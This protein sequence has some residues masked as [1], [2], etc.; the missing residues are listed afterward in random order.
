MVPWQ[1]NL[2]FFIMSTAGENTRIT[3]SENDY[4]IPPG[5]E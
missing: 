4:L 2:F 5:T 3:V 1:K